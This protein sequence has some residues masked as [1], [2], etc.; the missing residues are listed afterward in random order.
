LIL[1]QLSQY[2]GKEPVEGILPYLSRSLFERDPLYAFPFSSC[3][4]TNDSLL[5]LRGRTPDTRI[6]QYI[7]QLVE[8]WLNLCEH[9]CSEIASSPHVRKQKA[10]RLPDMRVD[11][12][13]ID[14]GDIFVL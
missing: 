9:R 12:L 6:G 14:C 1:P 13:S 8:R 7:M 4:Q 10:N 2:Q 3:V 5:R 11:F